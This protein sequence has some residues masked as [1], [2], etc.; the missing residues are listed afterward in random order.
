L[1][2]TSDLL[3][4]AGAIFLG[5][6]G[7]LALYQRL[8][9]EFGGAPSLLVVALIGG[10][11]HLFWSMTRG[12]VVET[13]VF[14]AVSALVWLGHRSAARRARHG[15]IWISI[16][17]LPLLT[18]AIVGRARDGLVHTLFS[19]AVGW[20]SLTPVVYIGLLGDVAYVR[21]N[22]VASLGAIVAVI[23]WAAVGA[24]M[25]GTP[26]VLAAGLAFLI[27]S[28]RTRP[29]AA[30]VPLVLLALLWNY[31]LMVQYTVGLLPKD[32]PVSFAAMVRQQADVHTSAPYIYPFSFPANLWFAWR[33]G[34]PADR[35]DL[36][37]DEPKRR[38]IDLTMDA[39]A[40]RFLLEG[41]DAPGVDVQR[42]VHWIG[43]TRATLAVPLDVPADGVSVAITARAR[44]EE[45]AVNA[46]MSL[47]I[48]GHE[49]GRFVVPATA[50]ATIRLDVP[51][52]TVGRVFRAGYNRV[53]I[54]SHGVH[55]VDPTD[56][57]PPG[58]LGSRTG[59]RAWPVAIYRIQISPAS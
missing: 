32:A 38:S 29:L 9:A 26:A 22:P 56:Q 45:P 31:W 18:A 14:G 43:E 50:P 51:A 48:N 12:A 24:P 41:W 2:L 19:S 30:V 36:L 21:R 40:A 8:R 27:A 5:A 49:I 6:G 42:P 10:A 47:E 13:G 15:A 39:N 53:T 1:L 28:A 20:L 54:V 3:P 52:A 16:I 25:T 46:D 37:A 4:L 17:A 35:Y 57:R 58:Q 33:E 23:T 44:L 34:V 11:T 55:R 59:N 7:L